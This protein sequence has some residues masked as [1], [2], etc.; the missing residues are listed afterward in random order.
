MAA[1]ALDVAGGAEDQGCRR[2]LRVRGGGQ[3][4]MHGMGGTALAHV[5]RGVAVTA[6][7]AGVIRHPLEVAVVG[8][9]GRVSRGGEGVEGCVH[10]QVLVVAGGAHGLPALQVGGHGRGGVDQVRP[11][12][13]VE[14]VVENEGAGAGAGDGHAGGAQGLGR[15][16]GRERGG[17]PEGGGAI[18]GLGPGDLGGTR[19]AAGGDLDLD[20]GGVGA[21]V[22]TGGRDGAGGGVGGAVDEAALGA[23][24]PAV[25]GAA[26][27]GAHQARARGHGLVGGGEGLVGGGA[28][29]DMAAQ[30]QVHIAAHG[31]EGAGGAPHALVAG[32]TVV[33]CPIGVGRRDVV[34]RVRCQ[35]VDAYRQDHAKEHRW[36]RLVEI[37]H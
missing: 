2:G 22:V 32:G 15:G 13:E 36:K 20:G 21:R 18:G 4:H 35:Q 9:A 31:G 23:G 25:G 37:S 29:G 10:L 33:E 6:E 27:G 24:I 8:G 11:D 19:G 12:I 26:G 3:V 16:A 1:E 17:G 30:A 14:D 5:A 28:A 34:R 7:G